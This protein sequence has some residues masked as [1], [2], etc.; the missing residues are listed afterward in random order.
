MRPANFLQIRASLL[1]GTFV[2]CFA[3]EQNQPRLEMLDRP[4]WLSAGRSDRENKRVRCSCRASYNS[5]FHNSRI[6]R[7]FLA[8]SFCPALLSNKLELILKTI[9]NCTAWALTSQKG[10][11]IHQKGCQWETAVWPFWYIPHLSSRLTME[12]AKVHTNTPAVLEV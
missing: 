9:N 10:H 6:N 5:V 7:N 4:I 12:G 1:R 2:L 11:L 8:P 3:K